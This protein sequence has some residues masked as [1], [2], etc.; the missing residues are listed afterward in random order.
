[1]ELG[2][3]LHGFKITEIRALDELSATLY[4]MSHEKSGAELLF[5]KRPDSNMTFAISFKTIPENDTG[6]FHIL[7]HSVLCGSEKFPI[8]EPF[9]DLLKSSLKTYLNAMTFPDKTVYPVSSRSERD[10]LGLIDVYMDAV[11][12]PN[13]LKRPEIFY[14]EGWHH[15]MHEGENKM[16]YKGVVFNEMKGAYSSVD[17]I[18]YEYMSKLLY[19]GTP[20]AYDSG[21][22]PT[23]IPDLTYEEFV[24]AHKKYYHPSNSKIILDGDVNLDSVL[25]LINSYLKEY[26][27]QPADFEIP[28][29][30][31]SGHV[32]GTEYYEISE[33]ESE[34]GKLRI[35][36]AFATFP[37][38][39]KKRALAL[40]V[41]IDAIA[42]SNDSPLRRDV[43]ATGLCED[44]YFS[45]MID[46]IKDNSLFL[47]I[48][49]VKEENKKKVIE[50][51]FEVLRKIV[52]NG[53]DKSL[54]ESTAD[55][56]EFKLREQDG[57][58]NPLGISY[59]ISALEF[60]LYGGDPLEGLE[61]ES[62]LAFLREKM[63]EQKYFENLLDEVILKS[64]HSACLFLRPSPTLGSERN[65]REEARL[66]KEYN[67]M[68]ES[69]RLATVERT[70][71]IEEW[72]RSED[73]PEAKATIPKLSISDI[74]ENPIELPITVYNIGKNTTIY[75]DVNSRGI[76]YL[77]CAFDVSDLSGEELF[78]LSLLGELYENVDTK[79]R[80]ASALQ[81][82]MKS[83]FG[84]FSVGV[85]TSGP[86]GECRVYLRVGMALLDAKKANACELVK[87]VLFD[88]KFDNADT[89]AKLIRQM[90][91]A[92]K[93]GISQ[94]GHTVALTR[95][96]AYVS[97]DAAASDYIDG[98]ESYLLLSAL[99]ESYKSNPALTEE[100]LMS[101]I[102][103][104]YTKNR[105]TLSYAGVRDDSFAEQI[106]SL[107]KDGEGE[108]PPCKIA[109]LGKLNE[110]IAIPAQV[111]YASAADS[112]FGKGE[113]LP[114]SLAVARSILSYGFLWNEI[115]VQG[116]AYGAGFVQRQNGIIGFYSYRDPSAGR[117]LDIYGR[118]A[119]F[120]R[121]FAASGADLTDYIIGTIGDIDPLASPK[122][123][124]SI[125]FVSY[126][127]G[128]TD[129]S[130]LAYRKQ[131][132]GTTHADLLTI[133]DMI[134]RLSKTNAR[135]VVGSK[136]IIK[137]AA[138]R[139]ETI[140]EI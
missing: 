2:Q 132:I 72:Q 26:D 116:G 82:K 135:C 107:F 43:L 77:W 8:K 89:I 7:E 58:G 53:I 109:P 140:V 99:D 79:A 76:T 63:S 56:M 129:E 50:K 92:A 18:E 100:K 13:A 32:E 34:E 11:L 65:A 130:R 88:S 118:S 51:T 42:G 96:S 73:T 46:G 40:A 36:L 111:S 84:S 48:K 38:Y 117:S 98:I 23:K 69:E 80:S 10:L 74:P 59:V 27:R 5:I 47:T 4:T 122:T 123:V 35:T 106:I 70:A 17:D 66:A 102:E 95:A 16:S 105:L 20:Y 85:F 125:A 124:A 127:R 19:R 28:S 37:Y 24:A 52:N 90:K 121:E 30:K 128:E 108:I 45:P 41:A 31:Y 3:I 9:V 64:P 6:V 119:D 15:E 75:T 110:G 134:D 114:G 112:A 29:L 68:N 93:E 86:I 97:T 49:N 39:E 25:P 139:L 91:L 113:Q 1:M 81:T 12:H 62:R 33:N 137:A 126:L 14:Q 131:L 103:R 67:A 115:R 87:E 94:S 54:L 22:D 133:A 101:L 57:G 61:F 78:M 104:V 21:G 120:L 136:S 71:R 83:T 60:W 55:R 138:D 44:I